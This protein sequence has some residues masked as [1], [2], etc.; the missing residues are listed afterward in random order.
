MTNLEAVQGNKQPQDVVG[1]L[2]DPED[3][4]ISHHSLHSR[5]L[6]THQDLA[7]PSQEQQTPKSKDILPNVAVNLAK[8]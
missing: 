5:I 4:Q 6:Q 1:A 8:F 2:E 7:D 3:P